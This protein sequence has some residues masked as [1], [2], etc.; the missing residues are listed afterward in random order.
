[1]GYDFHFYRNHYLSL[2]ETVKSL[3]NPELEGQLFS[4]DES[5][6]KYS[7]SIFTEIRDFRSP[8]GL[9]STLIHPID[10]DSM[11]CLSY[12]QLVKLPVPDIRLRY[13]LLRQFNARLFSALPFLSLESNS[14]IVK[15]TLMLR[16]LIFHSVKM[17]F[18]YDVMDKTSTVHNAPTVRYNRLKLAARLEKRNPNEILTDEGIL[19]NTAFGIAFSQLRHVDPELLRP[20]KPSGTEPHF[21]L[22]IEFRGEHVQG[23][24][25]PYRQF[26]TDVSRELRDVNS[27]P[28]LIPCPNA[29]GKVGEGRDK[30][31]ISP[32][33][34]SRLHLKMFKFLGQLM[35]MSIRTGV[36]L[37]LDLPPF[38]WKQLVS[39]QV[40]MTD[41]EAIDTHFYGTM[42]FFEEASDSDFSTIFQKFTV[43]LSDNSICLLKK[44]GD[45]IDVT[46]ENR[47]EYVKF[48]QKARL[49]E[50]SSQ[51]KAIKR[52]LTDVVPHHLLGLLTW[53]DLEWRICGKPMI[54]I[55]LLKRH[56][57]YNSVSPTAPHI[58]YFWQ[59]LEEFNQEDR[60]AFVR[61]VW[62]QERL[63]ANDQEFN[64]TATRM[65]IK[66]YSGTT[67]PDQAFPRAD[68]C[69]F[70]LFLPEYSSP[71]ILREKLMVACHFDA[72]SM[73]ADNV[74]PDDAE[75]ENVFL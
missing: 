24:G 1:M 50:C 66:P 70:N 62:G 72:D 29:K 33:A 39:A 68:T 2:E 48:A 49:N 63:P 75:P 54:D 73:N 28:L 9:K 64:R 74:V 57:V 47:H 26:F 65:L 56:T 55:K 31:V 32:S 20:K 27:L 46:F 30:Y 51:I 52:G 19:K 34:K 12:P 25:G 44:G 69:F 41:I 4:L 35:G 10:Q 14:V 11:H 61:F 3:Q 7:E 37:T 58:L 60:R 45:E 15:S 5:I 40:T 21:A 16:N 36:L 17:E 43:P 42:R 53:Q 8:I 13:E 71:D 22:L 18:F 6:V 38:F 59:V 23:E 67:S